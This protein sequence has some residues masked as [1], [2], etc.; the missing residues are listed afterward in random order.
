MFFAQEPLPEDNPLY[1]IENVIMTPHIGG[2]AK[3]S[4]IGMGEESV[5]MAIKI[6][7]EKIEEIIPENRVI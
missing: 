6:I 3:E 2:T 7:E 4:Y 1:E 5:E